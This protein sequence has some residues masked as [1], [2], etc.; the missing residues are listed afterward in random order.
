MITLYG[1]LRSRSNR[2]HWALEELEVDYE[3]YQLDFKKGDNRSAFFLKRNPS[4]KVPV[5]QD[6]D[7][8]LCESGAICNYLAEKY[9]EK[10]LIPAMG[11]AARAAYHQWMFFLQSEL[12]QPLWTQGKH[13]FLLPEELRFPEFLK[14]AKWEF[15]NSAKSASKGLADNE[16]VIGGRLT[17][18]DIVLAHTLRWAVNFKFDVE[19]QNLLR[20]LERMEKRP[21]FLRMLNSEV[22]TI[23]R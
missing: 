11:S 9:P 8:T 1:F 22:L 3:F 18:V 23:P 13:T 19:H 6:G 16:F 15:A 17:M 2:P 12:E 20:F 4:G 5:L 14:S 21:A 7:L 10:E